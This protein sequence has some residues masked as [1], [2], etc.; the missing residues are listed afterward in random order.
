MLFLFRG[1]CEKLTLQT[2]ETNTLR[3]GQLL[4]V[5][6]LKTI[7]NCCQTLATL[8]KEEERQGGERRKREGWGGKGGREGERKKRIRE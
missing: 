3:M 4:E 8:R 5:L 2:L 7:L 1:A 6:T